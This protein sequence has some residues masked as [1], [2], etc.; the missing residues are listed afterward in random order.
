M[1]S[2]IDTRIVQMQFDN[3]KFEKN[4]RTSEKSLDRFK[5]L[6]NFDSCEKSLDK[7]GKAAENLTFSKMEDN[8]QR[9]TD[10]FTGLG[11]VS[12]YVLSQVR[13]G[14]ESAAA[15]AQQFFKSMTIEQVN[16]GFEKFGRL[17]KSV[18]TIMA[19]TGRAEKDVYT[20]LKRLNQYTDQTSYNFTDMADNI[21]KFT[22]VGIGLEAAEKQMEGIA[23]WAA[24]SGGGIQEASRAMY[25]LSQAMGVGA[26]TKIDWK[27]IENAGMATKEYKE[28]L[29]QAGLATGNLVKQNGKVMTAKQFGKQIEVTYQNLAETLSKK[30]ADTEVM[31]KSFMAY[32]YED[33]YYEGEIE[34]GVKTTKEQRDEIRS[35]LSTDKKIDAENWKKLNLDS[36]ENIQ[37]IIDAAVEQKKLLKEVNKEGY[38]V[39]KTMAK[40][41]KQ[42]EITK[43][44]FNEFIER[45]LLDETLATVVFNLDAEPLIEAT[46]K[47]KQALK[48]A[49]GEDDIILKKDWVEDLANAGLATNEFKQAVIDA[50]VAAGTL[51]KETD[52]TGKT[53]YKT[54]KGF[55]KEM[56]VTLE[57][58][59]ESLKNKWFTSEVANR[60]TGLFNL[61]KAAY[62]S[63][64]KCM[65]FT[66]VLGAW[67]DQLSTGWMNSYNL[68]FGELSE[69]M[70]LFS[71]IC[72]KVGT[73]LDNLLSFRN[74]ILDTWGNTNGG[75]KGLWSLIVGE[76]KDEDGKV[77]AY[78]GAYGIL[79][80]FGDIGN[81]ISEGFFNMLKMF[82][83]PGAQLN[84]DEDGYKEAWL[85]STL[86]YAI[87]NVRNFIATIHD[88][89]T[90]SAD[91]SQKTRWQQ[92]QDVVNAIYA[93]F[94]LAY[95]VIRDVTT[96]LGILFDQE[97]FGP[98]IDKFMELFSELGLTISDASKDAIDGHG[99]IYLF[100]QLNETCA[101]LI[102]AINSLIGA[103]VD[104]A[105]QFLKT[106]R[107]NDGVKSF[108][109]SIVSGITKIAAAITK[110]GVPVI[111]FFTEMIGTIGRLLQN[112]INTET[113]VE[114][115]KEL[116]A[117]LKTM[118]DTLFSGI[119]N[120]TSRAK[121]FWVTI[122][123]WFTNGFQAADWEAVKAKVKSAIKL[124]LNALP[125]GWGEGI[126]NVYNTI[127]ASLKSFSEKV[128]A[129]FESVKNAFKNNF[130]EESLKNLAS[131]AKDLW[132][133]VITAIPEGIKNA[134]KSAY[135][136]VVG[137]VS[138]LWAKIT[139]FFQSLFGG[140]ENPVT[141]VVQKILPGQNVEK[142]LN[143]AK[144]Q[145]VLEKVS[146]WLQT[147][148]G[149]LKTAFQNLIGN[150]AGDAGSSGEALKKLDWGKIMVII[151]GVL[152]G[153]GVIT[154]VAKIVGLVKVLLSGMKAVAGIAKN[155]IKIFADAEPK[156]VESFGDKMLKIAGALAIMT[157]SL[158]VI[159]NLKADDAWR[160]L[161]ILSLL[162]VVLAGLGFLTKI[163]Y[164]NVSVSDATSSFIGMLGIA[165]AINR[166]VQAI[167]PFKDLDYQQLDRVLWGLT[168]V[169]VA[170]IAVAGAAKYGDLSFK[171]LSGVLALCAGIWLLVSS[172]LK[173]K[174][175]KPEQL[176]QMA[177]G[178]IFIL[179][180]LLTFATLLKKFGGS[181][182]GSGMKE[183]AFLAAAVGILVFSL[184]PLAILP[185]KSLLKMGAGLAAVLLML[186]IFIKSVTGMSLEG[187]SMVQLV[188]V[189]GSIMILVLA[190]LPLAIMPLDK[191]V[192]ALA[193]VGVLLGM[194]YLFIKGTKGMTMGASSMAQ[195]LA[196]AGTIILIV[197]A[198]IPLAI[199]PLD[200][201]IQAMVSVVILMAALLGFIVGVNKFASG[202]LSST[203]MVQLLAVAGAVA[204]LVITLMPLALMEW[205]QLLKMGAGLVAILGMFALIQKTSKGLNLKS[206]GPSL[207]M[208]I[209]L[210]GL[211]YVFAVALTKIPAD[212]DW[213]TILAFSGSLA[214]MI[215]A[216]AFA[217]DKVKLIANNPT[218][219]LKGILVI[220]VAL[221]AFMAV[222]A[223]VGSFTMDTI[224]S[225]LATLSANLTI[226]SDL[227]GDFSDNMKS[228]DEGSVDK[229]KRIIGSLTG[230]LGDIGKIKTSS[231]SSSMLTHVSAGLSLTSDMLVDFSVR[232]SMVDI[233]A[234]TK[235]QSI[236]SMITGMMQSLSGFEQYNTSREAFT[237][238][239][240]DLGT[241][242]EI[243]AGHTGNVGDLSSN[244]AL[245]LIKEL[246]ACAG[247]METISKMSISGLTSSLSGLGGAM[248]LYAKGAEEAT[249]LEIGAE[250]AP[251]VAGAV[252]LLHDISN[253]L[254]ENGGFT[255]PENMPS[256]E[257]LGAFG[258]QLAALA[259]ALVMFEEAGSKLGSG[260][261]KAIET[262]SFF[263]DLKNK[264]VEIDMGQALGTALSVFITDQ[265][266]QIQPNQMETFGKNIEQLG[267]ALAAFAKSTTVIDEATGAIMPV[268]Y[269]KATE[270]LNSFSDLAGKL[271]KIGGITGWLDGNR[272]SLEKLGDDIV[273][274]GS[275][276]K[277]FSM[278]VTGKSE[279]EYKGIIDSEIE[280]GKTASTTVIDKAV[281]IINGLIDARNKLPEEGNGLK[282]I[283][284]GKKPDL[285]SL[286]TELVELGSG[287][288][289][290]TDK[291]TGNASGEEGQKP[292]D[293][294]SAA[295]ALKI[296]ESMT[297][298][299]KLISIRLPKV[300]GLENIAES[301]AVGRF[302]SL[303]DVGRELGGLGDNLS[304][305]ATNVAGKF[306]DTTEMSNALG[307]V[308]Q[309]V[310]IIAN[311]AA[312]GQRLNL[313]WYGLDSYF[314]SINMFLDS[315][316]SMAGEE[317]TTYGMD[318][319]VNKIVSIMGSISQA[320]NEAGNIDNANLDVFS[321]FVQ[322]LTN[323]ATIKLDD[324][325]GMFNEVGYNISAGVAKGIR[326]GE[327]LVVEAAVDMAIHAYNATM[328]ALDEHSPSRLFMG[329]GAFASEGMAIG[330][331]K[332]AGLAADAGAEMANGTV[333]SARGI[334][335]NISNL[336]AS[337]IDAQPTI[338]PV[339]DLSDVTAGAQTLDGM[340]GRSYGVGLDT[341]GISSRASRS[342]SPPAVAV[343]NG[344]ETESM[345]AR[346]DAM[347]ESIQKMG[348]GI[349][350]MKL[351]LDTGVLAG[352]VT[353]DVDI[354]IGRKMFYAERRN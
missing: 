97:H 273:I 58:F 342:Y 107:E 290:F 90:A 205:D 302:A 226:F 252:R 194:I 264:L 25:N 111:N 262:L 104:L 347:L 271:P 215:A 148:F 321:T 32:Y 209:G 280:E 243:F 235:A 304:T 5:K 296:I 112:G 6:L 320:M 257:A 175:L 93:T 234:F 248:M 59:D 337:D 322:A 281:E 88:F 94:A 126:K 229:A 171:G 21:G 62:E 294:D 230:L 35:L 232:M 48:D 176:A 198:M 287:L 276:L 263:K 240:F 92:I 96:E 228:V 274:L 76:I 343:Q 289:V 66:D 227:I 14:L 24:R 156:K 127:R 202:G 208:M 80:V 268:D 275:S 33:L 9:L 51:K 231:E 219:A 220:S 339:L 129:F 255:I 108:W 222:F 317:E 125:E 164:K 29:I 52:K 272:E 34:K 11:T 204:L 189:A 15:K 71:N 301:I 331:E 185:V 168:G 166:V 298:T 79:D 132:S 105:V 267:K 38:T 151:L 115:G 147:S 99:L 309:T 82:A 83:D 161:G 1:P 100:V 4:I 68:I 253:S 244:S 69:S 233:L 122:K 44:N 89:F 225:S 27:S 200:R 305:F 46:D 328:A 318:S 2:G 16:A 340:F 42:I 8:L 179:G 241:S 236:I 53:V 283:W 12:E 140:K 95:T 73:A 91:G 188:A 20:V 119:P 207:L 78:E 174:D 199:M 18:Q 190:M 334:L 137:L 256:K 181:M 162:G 238:A 329:I 195:L 65:T 221:A 269:T 333:E 316:M 313:D 348:D 160:A 13:H 352:G 250:G 143:K 270:A 338:R 85:A 106:S 277:T 310:D 116:K 307:V 323:L 344:S 134:A 163:I 211:M 36:E 251:D 141:G 191:L 109:E 67:K 77:L 217:L 314:T 84:W 23:N 45:G 285:A 266:V 133:N 187:S 114:A 180:S 154:V 74:R 295:A 170:L 81:M 288:R 293:A 3:R 349:T 55:G 308:D 31:Q 101:P 56:V 110:Y 153:V 172:L 353:D 306:T 214:L 336:L 291:V 61:G 19:A 197:L 142:A 212:M 292:F 186:G 155:G 297:T 259:G 203:S 139:S 254:T 43:D 121:A 325:S 261:D 120:F 326:N 118:L 123:N 98:S 178:L 146:T 22:S 354:N 152:G 210:A 70:E 113:L 37:T 60:A 216:I 303:A 192:Q 341:S 26:L 224:G 223:L 39:Y 239:L 28:Q 145:N 17:N 63:A 345:M 346:M 201:L 136:A 138:N 206:V 260:K 242:V 327:S 246:S 7:F 41:G 49:L 158:T 279:G 278:K 335:A 169:V 330:I 196:V 86:Q 167:L 128:K 258:S 265:N 30:W 324:V 144:Q 159:A 284:T 117:S 177:G 75:R 183:A 247:D 184:L 315:F 57:N 350:N 245:Q 149:N 103:F 40:N 332:S 193:G 131:R 54:A 319:V 312:I 300:G 87:D 218:A 150:D 282:T 72:N 165:V 157:A 10:K 135:T 50:A 47:Q 64:Q 130:N 249:G 213:G 286:G 182:A 173:I 237:T 311:L 351:V 299:M 102:D 124:I